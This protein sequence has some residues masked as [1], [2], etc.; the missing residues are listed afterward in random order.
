LVELLGKLEENNHEYVLV[1]G[2]AISAFNP[3][4]STDLDIVISSND[5]DELRDFLDDEGFELEKRHKKDWF[6]D[7]EVEEYKKYLEPNLPVG[8]DLLVNGLGCRQTEAEWSF[9]YLR[10]HSSTKEVMAGTRNTTAQVVDPEV[11][12]ATKLHSGRETDLRD[13]TALVDTVELA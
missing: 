1:G 5:E 12:I 2:Y 10:E 3:R 7:R 9:N 13:V 4:F 11:L 8:F 6:Y